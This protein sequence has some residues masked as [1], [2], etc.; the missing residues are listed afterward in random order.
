MAE[1]E[2]PADRQPTPRFARLPEPVRPEDMVEEHDTSN[3]LPVDGGRNAAT[4][5]LIRHLVV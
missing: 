3:P 1:H 2:E 4:E 5:Y